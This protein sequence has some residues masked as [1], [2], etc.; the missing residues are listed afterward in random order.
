MIL[1]TNKKIDMR[2]GIIESILSPQL[3]DYIRQLSKYQDTSTSAARHPISLQLNC[4]SREKTMKNHTFLE[5]PN[6]PGRG[7]RKEQRVLVDFARDTI[8]LSATLQ[9][10]LHRLCLFSSELRRIKNLM[11][12]PDVAPFRRGFSASQRE[13]LQK[14]ID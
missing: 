8:F 2:L 5:L 10:P 11:M 7:A 3:L 14:K 13:Q 1:R 9:T 6:P 12:T 4:G